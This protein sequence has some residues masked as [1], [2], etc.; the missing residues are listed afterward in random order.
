MRKSLVNVAR[1]SLNASVAA[2]G[3]A[4]RAELDQWARLAARE[5]LNP[6][7]SPL[8]PAA[9]AGL[10]PAQPGARALSVQEAYDPQGMDF[11]CGACRVVCS[12]ATPLCANEACNQLTLPTFLTL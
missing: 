4:N 9:K 5:R 1:R 2:A 11:A 3:E 12:P 7:N 8:H 6:C 10:V